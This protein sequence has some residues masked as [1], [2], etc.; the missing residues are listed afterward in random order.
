MAPACLPH[1]SLEAASFAE[2]RNIKEP[3]MGNKAGKN[4]ASAEDIEYLM[5]KVEDKSL[6]GKSTFYRLNFTDSGHTK[7]RIT[8][9][10]NGEVNDLDKQQFISLVT[11]FGIMG[12]PKNF[13]ALFDGFDSDGDG[14]ISIKEFVL[15]VHVMSDEDP[16]EKIKWAFS[17]YDENKD[18]Q[19]DAEE[20][21][22]YVAAVFEMMDKKDDGVA[23]ADTV[24]EKLDTNSDGK[25]S[26]SEAI[27]ACIRNEEM[28]NLL[29]LSVNKHFHY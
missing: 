5:S 9:W 29:N 19:I 15:L 22:R 6:G 24:M 8:E 27:A 16:K 28:L 26:Q 23:L 12:T 1:N 14:V 2:S 21:K 18:G 25:I 17:T 3:K 20:M 13:E 11:E 4:K 7:A 10:Q